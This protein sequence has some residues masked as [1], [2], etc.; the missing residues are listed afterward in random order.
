[1]VIKANSTKV[2][3]LVVSLEGTD[4]GSQHRF[5]IGSA[6]DVNS[7]ATESGAFPLFTNYMTTSNYTVANINVNSNVGLTGNYKVGDTNVD[8]GKFTVSNNSKE[9]S[10]GLI[11]VRLRTD[12]SSFS[13]NVSN[14]AVYRGA[15]KIS[16]DVTFDGRYV[17]IKLANDVK[18][19]EGTV[20]YT[21]RGDITNVDTRTQEDYQL[22][23][24]RPDDLR[25]IEK[26]TGFQAKV[27]TSTSL[28]I[29]KFT[30]QGGDVILTRDTSLSLN[31][32]VPQ[33]S[34]EVSLLKGNVKAAEAFT[35]DK[36][37][38]SFRTGN[39]NLSSFSQVR[40]YIN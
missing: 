31:Q 8:L 32:T 28:V 20:Y 10:V 27:N 38:S 4:A 40:L 24:D 39:G 36:L 23:L 25:A 6:A 14:I 7:T 22:T 21:V 37:T 35:F 15:T 2:L 33:A 16:S 12:N 1:M 17:N 30:I 13:S 29:G 34:I 19:T 11:S 9:E 3:D 26:S 18:N 5:V